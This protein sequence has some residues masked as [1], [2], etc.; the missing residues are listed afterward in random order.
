MHFDSHRHLSQSEKS[1]CV[2]KKEK[3]VVTCKKPRGKGE[4]QSTD[5]TKIGICYW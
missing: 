2:Q 4:Y 1:K 5:N 3:S